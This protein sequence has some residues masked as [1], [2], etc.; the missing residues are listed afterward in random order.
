[1]LAVAVTAWASV[2]AHARH[3]LLHLADRRHL[4]LASHLEQFAPV[5]ERPLHLRA[6]QPALRRQQLVQR[7]RRADL[8]RGLGLLDDGGA[9]GDQ[10]LVLQRSAFSREVL[11]MSAAFFRLA[12]YRS[13]ISA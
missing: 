9:N 4:V 7:A 12:R 2:L 3:L 13:S 10:L 1:M 8:A 5:A 11:K 6:G